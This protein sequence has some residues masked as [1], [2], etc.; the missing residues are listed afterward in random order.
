M[1][2]RLLAAIQVVR[3][4]STS[5]ALQDE[6]ANQ[7]CTSILDRGSQDKQLVYSRDRK[8]SEEIIM[9]AKL[10]GRR[11]RCHQ[12]L[13]FSLCCLFAVAAAVPAEEGY[14]KPPKA[15][16]DILDAPPPPLVSVSPTGQYL[17]LLQHVPYPSI[18]DLAEPMLRL[19]G[20]RIN[21][22]T[23]GP[24]RQLRFINF[25]FIDI[26]TGKSQKIALPADAR[27]NFSSWSPDGKYLAFANTTSDAIEFWIVEPETA[28]ARRIPNVRLNA[29]YGQPF[30]WMPDSRTLLCRLVKAHRG[31][32]PAADR[33][34]TG[35][36]IQESSGKE[37]PVRTYQDLLKDRHDE[38]LF[39]YYFTSQLALVDTQANAVSPVAAPA[40][41]STTQPS[42]DGNHLLVAHEHRPYSYLHPSIAFPKEVEVWNLKGVVEFKV[43]SLPLAEQVPIEGVPTGPRE[44]GWRPTEPA[45]LVWAEALDGGDPRKKVPHRDR[46]MI[47]KS[48]FREE[49]REAA[50]TEHR[51]PGLR[52]GGLLWCE[53]PDLALLSDYD[54]DRRRR[55]TFA[56]DVDRP[57]HPARLIWD[58]S[59][60]D[61]YGD[62]GT[63]EM[64]TLANG[65]SVVRQK[66]TF[67]YLAGRGASPRG[68]HPF[69]DRFD[70]ATGK[71][72][73]LF[74]CDPDSFE[75]VW[76]VIDD[77][78]PRFIT[79]RETAHE[80][81]NYYVRSAGESS[82]R[83]LTNFTDPTPQL[84]SIKKELVTYKRADG[85]Q[86]SFTL[87]LPPDYKPGQRLP[88]IVWA[89][90]L[91]FTDAG[92][93][94]QVTGSPNYFTTIHGTSPLFLAI[95][96]YA[97]LENATMPVVGDPETVNNTYIEQIVASAAAAVDKAVGMG[98]TDRNRVGVGGHSYGAFMTANLLAHSN[99]FRAGVARSGA[100]N[101]TLTPFG[102]QSERRTLWQAPEMYVRV[103]PF[104]HADK[105][106]TPL[107]LIHGEADNNQ[108]TFPVQSERMYQAIKGNGGTVRYVSL[109]LESHGYVARESVEHT[110]YEM[111][112]WFDR[113]VK[114]A[115][116]K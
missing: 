57:E 101:R 115:S 37:A 99:L 29:T 20:H 56:I 44:Y 42:P 102:F 111:I 1:I 43:A 63:P 18:A 6:R 83:A 85:V 78:G 68:D 5:G 105:I 36:T 61:R 4:Q 13:C 46:I 64:K 38:E 52:T 9:I 82:K 60:L 106:K 25:S 31:E 96:G 40:I 3:R 71:S 12:I 112:S 41:F 11:L 81:P 45:T 16:T 87:Y 65:H 33:V 69:L 116:V 21:P 98:V 10:A 66:G 32:P 93:A 48:P 50:K 92:T 14:Q 24:A 19:A 95:Q 8:T 47:L 77:N 114:N 34:P 86:L 103:S 108:G 51:F 58:R 100:Y 27:P 53:R 76:A 88:T 72:E 109:P 113:Y 74:Q 94:S 22:Q 35:P 30:F 55:R 15:V 26:A 110:L 80:P 91:E 2:L 54:R 49:P 23:N 39:D 62:P 7:L 107:L 90:P 28:Q 89:Y 97:I 104:M 75:P 17:E 70:L 67:I 79:R 84:R 73:R 59:V